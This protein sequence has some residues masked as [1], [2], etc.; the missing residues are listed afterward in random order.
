MAGNIG[1]Y[2]QGILNLN[3]LISEIYSLA[4]GAKPFYDLT[5][6]HSKHIKALYEIGG[7]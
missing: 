5:K 4:D 6:P 3:K 2:E 7:E 1:L